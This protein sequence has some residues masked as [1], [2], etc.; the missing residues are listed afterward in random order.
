M[1]MYHSNVLV[2]VFTHNTLYMCIDVCVTIIFTVYIYICIVL[3]VLQKDL[4][5]ILI[6][7]GDVRQP[8]L[9][10]SVYHAVG[11]DHQVVKAL[12]E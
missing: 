12:E 5:G 4:M 1:I 7:Q 6:S 11:K 10:S 9:Q 8:D 2:C 3:C